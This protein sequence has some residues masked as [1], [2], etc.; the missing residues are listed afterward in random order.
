MQGQRL[1]VGTLTGTWSMGGGD[2]PCTMQ[3]Y[4]SDGI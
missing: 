1:L 4:S 2:Y 3:I